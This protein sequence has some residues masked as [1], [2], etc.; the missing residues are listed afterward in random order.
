MSLHELRSP[1]LVINFKNYLSAQGESALELA[2][3]A[4][5]VAKRTGKEIIVSPPAPALFYVARYVSIPVLAQHCEPIEY[6][7]STGY[8]PVKFLSSNG[9]RGSILN[10]SEHKL[11]LGQ[12]SLTIKKLKEERLLSLACASDEKEAEE[13][14]GLAP[15]ILAV[16]PPEL[17]GSGRAVSKVSPDVV[18]NSVQAVKR[19]NANVEVICGAGISSAEDVKLAIKLGA[20]GVL[21]ASAIV[22]AMDRE[23]MIEEMASELT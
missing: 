22:K 8:L 16:E 19:V 18:R 4:E 13:V 7:A 12:L 6:E 21:V 11:S 9:L 2:K 5:R 23:R 15:D 17:I 3:A 20:R 1:L 10:H 14:A